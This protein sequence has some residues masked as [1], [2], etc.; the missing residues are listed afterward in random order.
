MLDDFAILRRIKWV[1]DEHQTIKKHMKLVGDSVP[2]REALGSLRRTRTGWVPG[3]PEILA[4]NLRKLQQTLGFLDDGLK[5]HFAFEAKNLPPLCGDLLM[6]ALLIEHG[7]IL[8]KIDET[9]SVI[10]N[11]K[12]EAMSEEEFISQESRIQQ[13]ITSLFHSIEAHT[14]N[15]EVI[16]R[17]IRRVLEEKTKQKG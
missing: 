8:R 1:L 9:K 14:T 5:N 3:Q 2:D 15:E 11:A 16:L 6:Q 4:E 7:E 10:A 12:L 17:M 13:I